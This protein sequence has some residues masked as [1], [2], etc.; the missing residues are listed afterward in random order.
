MEDTQ[1]YSKDTQEEQQNVKPK[2]VM[3][4]AQ[5]ENLVKARAKA[6]ELRNKLKSMKASSSKKKTKLEV[7]LEEAE[8][9]TKIEAPLESN[10]VAEQ[11]EKIEE[12]R[13]HR[14]CYFSTLDI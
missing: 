14:N 1:E 5:K 12:N 10:K 7:E 11:E 8:N 13:I 9:N 3:T 6:L 2:R 4:E